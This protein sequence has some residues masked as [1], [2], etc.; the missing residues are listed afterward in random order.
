VS[1]RPNQEAGTEIDRGELLARVRESFAVVEP[2]GIRLTASFYQRLFA[3]NPRYRKYFEGDLTRQHERFLD[4][5]RRLVRQSGQLDSFLPYLRE[6]AR[7]HRKFG[8]REVHYRAFGR[9]LIETIAYFS[10]DAWSLETAAAWQA[11]YGLLASV[12]LAESDEADKAGPRYWN[13]EIIALDHVAGDT[14]ILQARP[15]SDYPY[16]AGQYGS[17]ELGVRPHVWRDL[18]F[19]SAP[20][21]DGSNVLEF[22]IGLTDGDFSMA[23]YHEAEVGG[24]MRVASAKG[25]LRFPHPAEAD[26]I[27]AVVH[28][29]GLAPVLA[30]L[31]DAITTSDTR[32]VELIA[33]ADTP[34]DHYRAEQ[35]AE[36]VAR[37][38][39]VTLTLVADT[40]APGDGWHG[41]VG[42]VA[43]A[44]AA[45]IKARLE[46]GGATGDPSRWGGVLVGDSRTVT[47]ARGT[48]VDAGVDAAE[49]R[50]DLF[51]G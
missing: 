34:R 3:A 10:G 37:H 20:A 38:G 39:A 25:G 28:G 21:A 31:Q 35:L 15:E 17:V 36:L 46:A 13:A 29:T 44:L 41:V 50:S 27:F 33:G 11:W 19:A 22:H 42:H 7:D 24:L 49:L 14:V 16:R 30:L 43:D 8:I 12:M 23:A 9:A 5:L 48:L 47:A 51:D 2:Y 40:V 6:L 18:S 32:E 26:L 45:R 4:A 1:K